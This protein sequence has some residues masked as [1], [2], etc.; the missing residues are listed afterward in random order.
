M[1]ILWLIS[2]HSMNRAQVHD[3]IKTLVAA[4][5]P[6]PRILELVKGYSRPQIYKKI[7]NCKSHGE[8]EDKPRGKRGRPSLFG[9]AEDE[10][11]M[12]LLDEDCTLW[13]SEIKL[14]MAK[15]LGIDV[16]ISAL[17]RALI[18]L[19]LKRKI[20]KREA[21][22]RNTYLRARFDARLEAL[23]AEQLVYV[24]ETAINEA[25]MNRRFGRAPTGQS[26][27]SIEP[28][29]RS[30]RW[31]VLPAYT[32]DGYLPGTLIA[33]GQSVNAAEFADWLE[34]TVLPQCR[35][36]PGARSVLVMDNCSTH[37]NERV[38][39]LCL[40]HRVLL[41]Y[42]PPYSPDYNPIEYTFRLLKGWMRG[43]AILAP[44]IADGY[45]AEFEAFIRLALD[46]W[47]RGVEHLKIFR[48]CHVSTDIPSE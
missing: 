29:R 43:N 45:E 17:S 37:R 2:L 11:L 7:A 21:A 28:L 23:E 22:G 44:E 14:E 32:V 9:A 10:F 26:P 40:Q 31:T 47:Q 25:T 8:C 4:G 24:D 34:N 36:F 39:E 46:G 19:G 42:L 18:R 38:R 33:H 35:P 1:L 13:L 16:S 5:T 48:R 6:T 20:L 27:I 15:Q 12:K 3:F 30:K 41:V